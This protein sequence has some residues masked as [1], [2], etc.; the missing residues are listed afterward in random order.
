MLKP[1][2]ADGDA[3]RLRPTGGRRQRRHAYPIAVVAAYTN[4]Q[5]S[6]IARLSQFIY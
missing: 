1:S 3:G 5:R 6:A 2:L 4:H